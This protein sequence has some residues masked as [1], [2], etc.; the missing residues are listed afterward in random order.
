MTYSFC[1]TR[2]TNFATDSS[3]EGETSLKTRHKSNKYCSSRLELDRIQ[4][5]LLKNKKNDYK[6]VTEMFTFEGPAIPC[7]G[8]C[9]LNFFHN[10]LTLSYCNI[11]ENVL[12]FPLIA[13]K[14]KNY[15]FITHINLNLYK[16]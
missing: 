9:D 4:S 12:S 3:I 5:I 7:P 13:V 2:D 16:V 15:H 8:N 6:N 14:K 11:V 10:V 1:T